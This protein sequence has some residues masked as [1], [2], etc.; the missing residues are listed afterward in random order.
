MREEQERIVR[1]KLDPTRRLERKYADRMGSDSFSSGW[2]CRVLASRS[3]CGGS[4]KLRSLRPIAALPAIFTDRPCRS[5][6]QGINLPMLIL[7]SLRCNLR[8]EK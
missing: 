3:V 2:N 5:G 8:S 7:L 1:S 4:T 6:T